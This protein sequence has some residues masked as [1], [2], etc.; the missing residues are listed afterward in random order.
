ME[1]R[2]S[3]P[4]LATSRS[5]T[6][7]LASPPHWSAQDNTLTL[8]YV[9]EVHPPL[10]ASLDDC[11]AAFGDR[12]AILSNSAGLKQYDPDGTLANALERGLSIPVL[13]HGESR[14]PPRHPSPPLALVGCGPAAQPQRATLSRAERRSV[15]S[16]YKKPAGTPEELEAHFGCAAH[17]LIMVHTHP[18]LTHAHTRVVRTTARAAER[19]RGRQ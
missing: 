15:S 3:T 16:A 1:R 13:R 12:L 14:L 6:P 19:C 11:R 4:A 9:L 5:S 10:R 2:S 8:P 17:Q 7:S 18:H